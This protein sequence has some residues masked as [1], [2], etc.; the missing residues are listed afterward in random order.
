MIRDILCNGVLIG[1]VYDLNLVNGVGFPTLNDN[2]FQFGYG[3]IDK[4]KELELHIHKRV[5]RIVKTTSEFLYVI[6]GLMIVDIYSEDEI[7]IETVSLRDNQ[8]LLQHFGGHKIILKKGTKYFEI[9]QGPYYG[10]NF[11][12]YTLNN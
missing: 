4:D 5:K 8:A 2:S 9:K 1:Q 12:K 3:V 10:R 11:D 6:N 7:F